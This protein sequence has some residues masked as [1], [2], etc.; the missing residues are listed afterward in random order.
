MNDLVKV[1]YNENTKEIISTQSNLSLTANYKNSGVVVC[2][3]SLLETL[4]KDVVIS[5]E[6][7]V[8]TMGGHKLPIDNI[9]KLKKIAC[10]TV[11]FWVKQKQESGY[12]DNDN[13]TW[14][15]TQEARM[16]MLGKITEMQL[17]QKTEGIFP[18]IHG[19]PHTLT[20]PHLIRIGTEVANYIEKI[21]IHG[22]Q[23][24]GIMN[25]PKINSLNDLED[26]LKE[27]IKEIK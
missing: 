4:Y 3:I 25:T 11:D 16:N 24:K 1:Y 2:D 9:T 5:G 6:K 18:D 7:E 13:I 12:T 19:T 27:I 10:Q 20:L 8:Q 17:L 26:L 23:L 15:T 21:Y 14:S 22:E